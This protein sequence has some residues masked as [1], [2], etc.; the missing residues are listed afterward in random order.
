[1]PSWGIGVTSSMRSIRKPN[2]ANAR[3][4]A[5]APGPGVLGPEPP[6]ARTLMWIAVIPLSLA[7]SAAPVAARMAAY[8]DDS[9]R[10]ALTNMPPLVR[11]IVS[12]PERSVIWISVLL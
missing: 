7:T 6:G 3:M 10:S 9:M 11:A 8:G 4:A 1:M 2:L 5:C 12:A